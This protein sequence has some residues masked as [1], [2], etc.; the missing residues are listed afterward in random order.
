M[1]K[2][3]VENGAYIFAVNSKKQNVAHIAAYHNKKSILEY[4]FENYDLDIMAKDEFWGMRT[5]DF[6]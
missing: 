2:L 1:F 3:L 4:I 5:I 6:F